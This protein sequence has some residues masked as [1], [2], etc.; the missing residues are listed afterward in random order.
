MANFPVPMQVVNSALGSDLAGTSDLTPSMSES[1]GRQCLVENLVRRLLTPRGGLVDDPNYGYLVSSFVNDDLNVADVPRLAVN[2]ANEIAKDER[3]E[4]VNVTAQFVGPEQV[5]AAMSG[6]VANP[7]PYP[8]GVLV[9]RIG[10]TD[11]NG[12]F[13]LVLAANEV[14]VTILATVTT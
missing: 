3:V 10:I 9:I 4:D 2:I 12:P 8:G 6:T 7:Q 13:V 1:A 14:T 5:S 11:S